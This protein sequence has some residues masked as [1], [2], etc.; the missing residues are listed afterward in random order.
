MT[1]LRHGL[2]Y[3]I[4]YKKC[5][6][7]PETTLEPRFQMADES[8]RVYFFIFFDPGLTDIVTYSKLLSYGMSNVCY[9]NAGMMDHRVRRFHRRGVRLCACDEKTS[10][11]HHRVWSCRGPRFP[12]KL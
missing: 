6:S 2:G 9:E 1:E 5:S 4:N 3:Q 11:I 10:V 12:L 8:S 7:A